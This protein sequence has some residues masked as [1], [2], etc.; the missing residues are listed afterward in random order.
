VWNL[1]PPPNFQG[2]RDDLPL[3]VYTRH[4]PHW[5]Q[6]NATYFVT[7]RLF[8]S[9]PASRI[10]E[11]VGLKEEWARTH[12]P[13]H[14]RSD[15]EW[16]AKTMFVNVEKW[17]DLGSGCCL[18]KS[19]L[20]AQL[21][22]N[23]LL[24]FHGTRYELGAMVVMANH[25]HVIVRPVLDNLEEILRSW[26]SFTAHRINN[27]LQRKGSVWQAE[28]HDRIIRDEEHLWRAIQYIGDNPTKCGQ[29]SDDCRLWIN[30]DWE[31]LGWRYLKKDTSSDGRNSKSS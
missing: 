3:Q 11:L 25:V 1:N 19:P 24:F 6:I 9:L 27:L 22:A 29:S 20:H 16:L 5:R 31:R 26:K 10:R 7:F 18:L 23:S 28:S 14:S 21:V 17:L 15:L 4:L 8:D 30:P 13:P 2:L 12:P